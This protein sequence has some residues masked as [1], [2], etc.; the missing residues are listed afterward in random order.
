MNTNGREFFRLDY[1]ISNAKEGMLLRP[2]AA[3]R[4]NIFYAGLAEVIKKNS[5]DA[6]A[7]CSGQASLHVFVRLLTC[8]A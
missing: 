7:P 4:F 1:R 6:A 3:M 2:E 5:F 8:A